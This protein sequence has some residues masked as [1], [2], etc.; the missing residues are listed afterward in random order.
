MGEWQETP[1]FELSRLRAG[2]ALEGPAIVEDP[3]TTLVVPPG[4]RIRL[5]EYRTIWMEGAR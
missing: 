5:D 2:N 3:T 1:V 4:R